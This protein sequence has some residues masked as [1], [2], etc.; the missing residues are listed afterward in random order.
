MCVTGIG[1]AREWSSVERER[2]HVRQRFASYVD[3]SLV[4]YVLE[5]PEQAH[6]AGEVRE[7]TVAFT[8]LEHYT[9]LTERLRERAVPLLNE[10]LSAMTPLI[11]EHNG[12]RSKFLGDGIM[13]FYGAPEWNCDHAMQAV[14]TVLKMQET[15]VQ[16]NQRLGERGLPALAMRI[17]VNSGEMIV[18]DAGSRE[19]SDYTVLGDAVNLGARL[20]SANKVTGTRILVSEG[21]V[22]LLPH[23][24]FL[25]RPIGRLQVVGLSR[26]VMTYE[27]LA[28]TAQATEAQRLSA[29]LTSHMVEHFAAAD[30]RECLAAERCLR[31]TFGPS[32]LC[33]LYR[34]LC[35]K[36]IAHA[37]PAG[38]AGGI[39][40]TEK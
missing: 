32:K 34:G 21:T 19:A 33:D 12:Y 17:G 5:H 29:T 31:E 35:E 11:R 18:G 15:M 3:P 26:A 6:F 23:D 24:L 36:Y 38:F 27:P 37:P 14:S 4:Q 10:Y 7:L 8:D 25:L 30:F 16:L 39:I 1:L 28:Y 20:E 22:K 9:P 40:L 13:F 2:E